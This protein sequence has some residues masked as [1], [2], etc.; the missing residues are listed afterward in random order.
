MSFE[1]IRN[2]ED[3]YYDGSDFTL[4]DNNEGL[5]VKIVGGR[6]VN[7][8]AYTQVQKLAVGTGASVPNQAIWGIA[9]VVTEGGSTRAPTGIKGVSVATSGSAVKVK[10]ANGAP[11]LADIGGVIIPEVTASTTV[12]GVAVDR[13]AGAA[14]QGLVRGITGT[15]TADFLIVDLD[16]TGKPS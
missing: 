13:T 16:R 11:E 14:G 9:Q 12:G 10:K 2:V 3:A 15:T 5:A 6:I 8:Q 7:S 4:A 1:T